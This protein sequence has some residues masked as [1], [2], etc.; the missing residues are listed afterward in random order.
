MAIIEPSLEPFI[1]GQFPNFYQS[2]SPRYVE[3]VKQYY[4]WMEQ[5]GKSLY[6]ARNFLLLNDVDTATED[7]L[8]FIKETYLKNIQLDTA[9]NIRS[10]IKHSLDIYRSKGSERCIDLLF[11]LVFNEAVDTYYPKN[12]LFNLSD[13]TWRVPRYIELSLNP[14]N[15]ALRH[16]I[17]NG[18]QSGADAFVDD[19]IR[20]SVRGILIDVAYISAISGSFTTGEV[21]FP[22]D[23]SLT[24]LDCPRMIGSLTTI[25]LTSFGSGQGYV[26]G[27]IV[28]IFSVY[29]EQGKALVSNTT[30]VT[31]TVVISANNGGYGYTTSSNVIVAD[32]TLTLTNVTLTNSYARR[33]FQTFDTL[34][35][36]AN[37]VQSIGVSNVSLILDNSNGSFIRDETIIQHNGRWKYDQ[38]IM[39]EAKIF[40]INA[41]AVLL[42]N[43]VGIFQPNTA[44]IGLTSGATSN[45]SSITL[46]VGVMDGTG[47][48]TNGVSITAPSMTG[49]VSFVGGLNDISLQVAN[50][51]LYTETVRVNTDRLNNWTANLAING[52]TNFTNTSANISSPFNTFLTYA[53]AT[54]GQINELIPTSDNFQVDIVPLV[55]VVEPFVKDRNIWDKVVVFTGATSS[56]QVNEVVSQTATGARGLVQSANATTLLIQEL[57][58]YSN[59][60]FRTTSNVTTQ[61]MGVTSGTVANAVLVQEQERIRA[62]GRNAD[63]WSRASAFS[64]SA[65]ELKIIN[66]GFGHKENELIWF[67]KGTTQDSNTGYGYTHLGSYGHGEG[68]YEQKG[69]FLS[70]QKKLFDGFYYQNYSYEIGSSQTIDKYRGMMEQIAHPAG[71][72]LFG[73]Y[74]YKQNVNAVV[75]VSSDP[76]ITTHSEIYSSREDNSIDLREDGSFE[77]EE[78]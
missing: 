67:N 40:A 36:G 39:G 22:T 52:W 43:V 57:R 64:G 47:D 68:F 56:F 61:I 78:N 37:T 12:D 16:K 73:K 71:M 7:L 10:I 25:E 60:Q 11:R 17:V 27:D 53:N 31:G 44:V 6:Y 72:I 74:V 66:S 75:S 5:T 41:T 70:D 69:G 15:F 4:L 2:D 19:V 77:L 1:K 51:L 32:R 21:I 24:I 54:I 76:I 58:F 29:G 55:I 20:R 65:T 26:T 13:G 46:D 18:L 14:N 42:T 34:T 8:L 33:F 63:I 38:A 30:N 62:T 45:V 35:Q 23:N 9:A 3:F 28:N 59:Q 49:D 50:N 48:V